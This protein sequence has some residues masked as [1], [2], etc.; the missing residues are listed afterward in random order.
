MFLKVLH[1]LKR[2]M[3]GQGLPQAG[4][5]ALWEIPLNSLASSMKI[6]ALLPLLLRLNHHY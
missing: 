1:L 2:V 6:W 3:Y 5:A 4:R